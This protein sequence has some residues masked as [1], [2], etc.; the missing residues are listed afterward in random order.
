MASLQDARLTDEK[1]L[2]GFKDVKEIYSFIMS[3]PLFDKRIFNIS[4]NDHRKRIK[5]RQFYRD[6]FMD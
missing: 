2:E 5:M 4:N 1:W 3:T 6:F